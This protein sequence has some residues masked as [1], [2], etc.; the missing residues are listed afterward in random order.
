[1]NRDRLLSCINIIYY[2]LIFILTILSLFY[3]HFES[4]LPTSNE[5]LDKIIIYSTGITLLIN[6]IFNFFK[7]ANKKIII[8]NILYDIGTILFFLSGGITWIFFLIGLFYFI[9]PINGIKSN[10]EI[11]KNQKNKE[12]SEITKNTQ[13]IKNNGNKKW[14]EIMIIIIIIF[15]ILLFVFNRFIIGNLNSNSIT[16]SYYEIETDSQK[17]IEIT[18]KEQINQIKKSLNYGFFTKNN[19]LIKAHDLH[20]KT[21]N[22]NNGYII[23]LDSNVKLEYRNK[24]W[25]INVS[26]EI[27]NLLDN[28]INKN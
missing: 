19:A 13:K 21:L 15:F 3:V 20:P 9:I 28:I 22:F 18:N 26:N 11:L 14:I 5:G 2:I 12:T 1:M 25:Y 6:I 16:I 7:L 23:V 24:Y 17:T 27:F 8:K 4:G 10:I